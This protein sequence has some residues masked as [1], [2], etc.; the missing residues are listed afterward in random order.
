MAYQSLRCPS[1]KGL[2]WS[3]DGFRVRQLTE[4]DVERRRVAP[5]RDGTGPW[6]CE[7]C[8][9]RAPVSGY[10]AAQLNAAQAAADG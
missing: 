7:R 4:G 6:V 3:R 10:I 8:L 5:G 1:C 9:Y 2:D